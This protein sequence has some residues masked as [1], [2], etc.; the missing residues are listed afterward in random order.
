L[1][2]LEIGRQEGAKVVCG[3]DRLRGG[4]Y[5]RGWFVAP[6]IFDHVKRDMRIAREEIF[7][8]VLSVLRVKDYEEALEVANDVIYGLSSSIYT[9]NVAHIFDFIDRIESGIT[10][11]NS[12]T[13]GGE[14]QM[15]FGG[16]KGTGVGL[17][18][19]GNVALDFFTELKV[20]YVDYTGKKRDSN[21]Y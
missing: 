6:T 1:S 17:R 16:V 14:A 4:N 18:E 21:I 8:P 2:Y 13:T 12:A 11:V 5:D 3:G 20:V 19:Q 10:H 9:N 7:G 15:P